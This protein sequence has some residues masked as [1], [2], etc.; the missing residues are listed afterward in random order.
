MYKPATQ[1]RAVKGATTD[2]DD[3]DDRDGSN[4]DGDCGGGRQWWRRRRKRARGCHTEARVELAQLAVRV[5]LCADD[6]ARLRD[7]AHAL[8][9][10]DGPRAEGDE[11]AEAEPEQRRA[12]LAFGRLGH[13][14][15]D[16]AGDVVP[17]AEHADG[18]VDADALEE[19]VV[20]VA[21]RVVQACLVAAGAR[22]EPVAR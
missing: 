19:A 15:L 1:R 22:G 17:Q 14:E 18:A 11:G 3:R 5:R 20:G 9:R 7:G 4:D 13:R 2:G 10:R 8:A 12:G 21:A 6:R 16:R